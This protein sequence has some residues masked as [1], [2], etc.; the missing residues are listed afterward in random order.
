MAHISKALAVGFNHLVELLEERAM[1][2]WHS[3]THLRT[4]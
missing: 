4:W 2:D 3:T 1:Y